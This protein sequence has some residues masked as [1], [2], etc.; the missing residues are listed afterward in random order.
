MKTI[1]VISI[2]FAGIGCLAIGANTNNVTAHMG[3][4]LF[5][6]FSFEYRYPK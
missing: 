2:A 5:F 1:L 6:P 4:T 3:V